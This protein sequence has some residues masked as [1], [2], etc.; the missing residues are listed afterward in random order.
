VT[1]LL[2]PF[3]IG[4]AGSLHCIGMCSPLAMAVSKTGKNA[5]FRNLQY[6]LGR[7][8]TY[9][10]LGS[11]AG[12]AGSG[13]HLAGVQRW[14]SI[15]AGLMLVAI[16]LANVRVNTPLFVQRVIL[17]FS[18]NLKVQFRQLLNTRNA[19]GTALLGA[20]NGLL[21]CGLT[22]VA[23]GYCATLAG[24]SEGFYA[25]LFFG[26][27]TLPAMVGAAAITRSLVGMLK[28]SYDK[29]QS[30]LLILCA[31]LLIGRGIWHHQSLN[32]SE[33]KGDIIVCG[34]GQP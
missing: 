3:V 2:A 10:V 16:V 6:N 27:G 7:I 17:R 19:F 30:G 22:L 24:P 12:F 11:A 26:L 20:I 18:N 28:I 34:S 31:I 1:T 4:L 5:L 13:L 9:G 21:P 33:A 29:L 32:N 15:A 23:L 8:L 14:V 25:M